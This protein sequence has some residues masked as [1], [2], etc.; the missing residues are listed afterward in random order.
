MSD[1]TMERRLALIRSIREENDRNRNSLLNREQ[2]LYGQ[3]AFLP[4]DTVEAEP[5]LGALGSFGIRFLFSLVVFALFVVWDYSKTPLFGYTPADIRTYL[6][7]NYT[8]KDIDF[9]DKIP[10]TLKDMIVQEEEKNE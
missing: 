5:A 7:T 1:L 2:I 8:V 6:E 3:K 9:A 4:G 10:Y